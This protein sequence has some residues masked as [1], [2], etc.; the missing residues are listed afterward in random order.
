MAQYD[1]RQYDKIG[2]EYE[3]FKYEEF[4]TWSIVEKASFLKVIGNIKGKTF[5]DLACGTGFYTRLL[6]EKGATKVVGVD[7]SEEMVRHARQK[8]ANNPLG[9]EYHVRDVA[10]LPHLG[11]FDLVTAVALLHYAKDRHHLLEMLCHII[12]NL[13]NGGQF[14][15]Y[16]TN[17]DF[18][19]CK[20]NMTPYGITILQEEPMPDGRTRK[21]KLN[22]NPPTFISNFVYDRSVY[23][24][25]TK[26]AGFKK[27]KWHVRPEV[28][29]EAIAK[30]GE[31]YWQ[32][33]LNNPSGILI[34]C[35]K[36]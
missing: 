25:A 31:A 11:K 10:Q 35:E 30:Y 23:E 12:D 28:P 26:E 19:L 34:S 22:T 8:E 15:T 13:R 6:K 32:D 27:L 18:S 9:I 29:S 3:Q 33:L 16:I 36:P 7:I 14:V 24:W 17:P 1:T 4:A 5:L 2:A 21:S 20:S